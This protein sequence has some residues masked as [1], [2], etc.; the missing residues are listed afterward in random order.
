MIPECHR[1]QFT[2]GLGRRHTA[3]DVA[4]PASKVQAKLRQGLRAILGEL[5][6]LVGVDGHQVGPDVAKARSFKLR[7]LGHIKKLAFYENAVGKTLD[8]LIEGKREKTSGLLKGM[9][10]NY[11][12]VL[13]EGS[14][15]LENTL[16]PV[17]MD[18][19]FDGH[20]LSGTTLG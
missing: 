18:R 2:V 4:V 17:R 7:E 1:G 9:T 3:V 11:L 6:N 16:V 10:S 19:L 12:T 14:D 8:V 13:M 5:A 20:S 15:C